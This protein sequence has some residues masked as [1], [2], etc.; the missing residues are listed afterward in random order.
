MP[1]RRSGKAKPSARSGAQRKAGATG[2]HPIDALVRTLLRSQPFM[3]AFP[4]PAREQVLLGFLHAPSAQPALIH[5]AVTGNSE[6]LVEALET[7]YV[8]ELSEIDVELEHGGRAIVS[9]QGGPRMEVYFTRRRDGTIEPTTMQFDGLG[10]KRLIGL[11]FHE[12][13]VALTEALTYPQPESFKRTPRTR[14]QPGK[15]WDEDFFRWLLDEY[16]RLKKES[17]KRPVAELARRLGGANRDTVK[18]WLHRGRKYLGR[19]ALEEP[20]KATRTR[21]ER[22]ETSKSQRQTKPK[23]TRQV[24][25]AP[26][27]GKRRG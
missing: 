26:P 18:S 7:W 14:P 20:K 25:K 17:H 16:D 8:R 9:R 23:A 22:A 15:P 24:K 12:Y 6:A 5:Y 10:W 3:A 2:P 11:P 21:R 4:A 13:L 19:Q 1:P 27:R